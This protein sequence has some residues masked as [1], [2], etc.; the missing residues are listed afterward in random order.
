M[1]VENFSIGRTAMKFTL[2]GKQAEYMITICTTPC[3]SCPF[4]VR[5]SLSRKKVACKHIIWV[6]MSVLKISEK[7]DILQQVAL[8]EAEV[9]EMLKNAP[10][11]GTRSQS[12][13]SEKSTPTSESPP[14]AILTSV[15]MESIFEC[16]K[17]SQPVQTWEAAKSE[18]RVKA[19][20]C[21]CKSIMPAGKLF[22]S[23]HGLYI[24]RGQRFAVSRQFYFCA[25]LQCVQKKPF[26]SNLKTPPNVI[27][28]QAGSLLSSEDISLLQSR[29]LPI[30]DDR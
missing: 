25:D 21:S 13:A 28:I 3:C 23:V 17:Y 12:S 2:K 19:S 6:M 26:A 22:I 10:A 29:G 27:K 11:E 20:C 16:K 30:K 8:T 14:P 4:F 18:Q 1:L 24:P 9:R 7:S 15:E 5:N